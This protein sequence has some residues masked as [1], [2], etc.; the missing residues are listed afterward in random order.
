MQPSGKQPHTFPVQKQ[1]VVV[2]ARSKVLDWCSDQVPLFEAL[3][4]ALGFHVLAFPFMW[5]VGWALPWPKPPVFTTIIEINLQNWPNEAVPEK[6]K[7]YLDTH[8]DGK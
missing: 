5:F 2:V 6:I 3:C 1:N 4:V 7:Q 8:F